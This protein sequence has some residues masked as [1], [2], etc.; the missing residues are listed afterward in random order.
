ME[1]VSWDP[2]R[3]GI[4]YDQAVA[5]I[6]NASNDKRWFFDS[7]AE[8]RDKYLHKW[9][10]IHNRKIIDSDDDFDH[11]AARLKSNEVDIASVQFEF[12]N[13]ENYIQ[14]Y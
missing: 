2:A 9:I 14:I 6:R 1:C 3:F 5:A 13:E 4:S 7:L 8:F 10:A 11:L 12:V